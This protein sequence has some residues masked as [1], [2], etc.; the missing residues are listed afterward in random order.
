MRE[1]VRLLCVKFHT[2]HI[3]NRY[4]LISLHCMLQ[5]YT[6]THVVWRDF[7]VHIKVSNAED[8]FTRVLQHRVVDGRGLVGASLHGVQVLWDNEN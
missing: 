7:V 3:Q 1:T 6:N 2:E 4:K 5:Y 8:D